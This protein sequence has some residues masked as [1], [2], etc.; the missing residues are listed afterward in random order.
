MV[1]GQIG[2][3]KSSLINTL[4]T[5]FRDNGQPSTIATPRGINKDSSTKTVSLKKLIYNIS[6]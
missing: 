2:A 5:V 1:I 3:G 6:V 4:F